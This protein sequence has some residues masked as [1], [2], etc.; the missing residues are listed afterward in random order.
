MTTS[1]CIYSLNDNSDSL[2]LW[3][4]KWIAGLNLEGDAWTASDILHSETCT[5]NQVQLY[6]LSKI[7]GYQQVSKQGMMDYSRRWK[8]ETAVASNS[9]FSLWWSE[10]HSQSCCQF[11]SVVKIMR[12]PFCQMCGW[13]VI[14]PPGCRENAEQQRQNILSQQRRKKG[15]ERTLHTNTVMHVCITGARWSH[16]IL[17]NTH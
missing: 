13:L 11:L 16:K 8:T 3:R 10:K 17:I 4:R 14:S 7:Q 5:I 6:K 9:I 12:N 15:A 1:V 2:I